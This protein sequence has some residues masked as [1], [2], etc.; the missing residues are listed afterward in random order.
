M[1]IVSSN[2]IPVM[3]GQDA[4]LCSDQPV[5]LRTCWIYPL[6]RRTEF[7]RIEN[8]RLVLLSRFQLSALHKYSSEKMRCLTS[9]FG[10][11]FGSSSFGAP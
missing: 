6:V 7:R 8:S 9:Y 11:P 5:A 3:D 4:L 1:Q 10:H 2:V